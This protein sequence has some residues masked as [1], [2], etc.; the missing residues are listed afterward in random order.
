MFGDS[1][2]LT[3]E[4][5]VPTVN[6]F[7]SNAHVAY[8]LSI[9]TQ[10]LKKCRPMKMSY[11]TWVERPHSKKVVLTMLALG[12]SIDY[13]KKITELPKTVIEKLAQSVPPQS[14]TKIT[15]TA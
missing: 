13:I 5:L 4:H 9:N 12:S 2:L 7:R 14:S 3:T 15:P 10:R 1:F 8:Q 6:A 11:G